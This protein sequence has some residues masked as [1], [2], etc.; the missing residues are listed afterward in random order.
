MRI[1]PS[2]GVEL[3]DRSDLQAAL[4]LVV[5]WNRY[6]RRK[7]RAAGRPLAPVLRSGVR[8][9]REAVEGGRVRE[10]WQDVRHLYASRYGDCEDLACA[11]A[12][13]LP[14]ARAVP[15]RSSVGW[16]V[17]VLTRD[18]RVVDPSRILGMKANA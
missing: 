18:G 1:R 9:R 5:A 12:A 13:E 7:A 14:G 11:L 16:H 4:D 3:T 15:V 2:I 17:V 10:D 6:V 8:Y